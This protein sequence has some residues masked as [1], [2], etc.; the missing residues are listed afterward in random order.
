[1]SFYIPKSVTRLTTRAGTVQCPTGG[2][3]PLKTRLL[4]VLLTDMSGFTEY[5][6]RADRVDVAAAVR[7]QQNII[8][9]VIAKFRGRLVKWIGDAALAT[10]DAATDAVLCGRSIQTAFIESA[11]RGQHLIAPR[12]KIVVHAG[13]VMIDSD[14]DIYG[15]VVN[16]AARMEKAAS[17]NEVYFSEAVRRVISI[18]EIPF[19]VVGEFQFKGIREPARVYRTCFGETPVVRER[20]ALLQTNFVGVLELADSFGWDAIHPVLDRMT[21]TILEAARANGGTGR[22]TLQI[23]T[24]IT[25]ATVS[26]ALNA[27]REWNQQLSRLD[28]GR[29]DRA[30][31]KIR[32]AIHLGTLHIMKHT[33]M[34]RDID[35]VRT[36]SALGFGTEIL[37]TSVAADA[38]RTEG[39][40]EQLFEPVSDFRECSSKS[41]WAAKFGEMP[42]YAIKLDSLGR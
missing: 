11:E 12:L 10:F 32:A 1:M 26:A 30:V 36:L 7:Q 34:G 5:S 17:A 25:F 41:R 18:A 6:S 4:A 9:P 33:M 24:F 23:G 42:V 38:A 35:V 3:R 20:L 15:D 27:S 16:F 8:G 40:P 21:A 39:L 2:H 28:T 31:L 19:E 14:G 29:L 13:D 37:L 22:G